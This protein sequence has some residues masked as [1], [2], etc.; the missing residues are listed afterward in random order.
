[1]YGVHL[2][3]RRQATKNTKSTVM[4]TTATPRITPMVMIAHVGMFWPT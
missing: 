3:T 1:M 4:D 2:R